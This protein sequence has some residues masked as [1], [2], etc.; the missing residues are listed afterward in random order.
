MSDNDERNGN[1]EPQFADC[2]VDGCHESVIVSEMAYHVDLHAV[3]EYQDTP[4]EDS[5]AISK[6]KESVKILAV[7]PKVANPPGTQARVLNIDGGEH[8]TQSVRASSVPPPERRPQRTASRKSTVSSRSVNAVRRSDTKESREEVASTPQPRDDS[9]ERHRERRERQR[10]HDL[11]SRGRGH[12]RIHTGELGLS[13]LGQSGGSHQTF[14]SRKPSKTVRSFLAM[15]SGDPR[16]R[17]SSEQS[18]RRR[19]DRDKEKDKAVIPLVHRHRHSSNTKNSTAKAMEA[20][21]EV[22][23]RLGK[24]EL[25][26]FA[27]EERMPDAL[28]IYLKTEWGVRHEGMIPF[29][30][31]LLEQ[32]PTTEYAYL[33]DPCVV[34]V[35]RLPK[36]GGFC[37][38]RNIQTMTSYMVGAKFPGHEA[39]PTDL[40]SVFDLQNLIESAWDKGI[41]S[42][43]RIE[44]G[45]IRLTRK[46]IGTP[47]AVALFQ[48][49]N[50][51]CSI[52]AFKH[53]TPEK[54]RDALL[55]DVEHYFSKGFYSPGQKVRSTTLP[56]IYWQHPGHSLTIVGIEKTNTGEMNLL[57]FDPIFRNGSAMA[58]FVSRQHRLDDQLLRPYRRG[59]RYLARY[60]AFEILKLQ[61]MAKDYDNGASASNSPAVP[62]PSAS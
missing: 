2:P 27:N 22:P 20:V 8:G 53:K 39:F 40:P 38:Y 37:G 6:G 41:N 34:H 24:A 56:P 33:C 16:K 45:G 9:R 61:P 50:I 1:E 17:A 25:G 55:R 26:K 30:Q 14:L 43:G 42:R 28:A 35:S 49:L 12:G 58:R 48:S 7:A 29:L 47:E 15:F 62:I 59:T 4:V 51:P 57:V 5:D 36:E 21:S 13:T 11:R 18:D 10:H 54:S 52:N 3:L 46:Y 31:G 60:R 19:G 32:N 44:T 23:K